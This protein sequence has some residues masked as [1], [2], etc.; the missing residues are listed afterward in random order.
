MADY[1]LTLPCATIDDTLIVSTYGMANKL[2]PE[3]E[4]TIDGTADD[5]QINAAI[6]SASAGQTVSLQGSSY[7]CTSTITINKSINF[8]LGMTTIIS[9]AD[10]VIA[11]TA[12]DVTVKGV[13]STLSKIINTTANETIIRS[14]GAARS[15]ITIANLYLEGSGPTYVAQDREDENLIWFGDSPD[16]GTHSNIRILNNYLTQSLTGI[17]FQSVDDSLI[18]GNT[19]LYSNA[20]GIQLNLWSCERVKIIGNSFYDSSAGAINAIEFLGSADDASSEIVVSNNT[21]WGSY[22]ETINIVGNKS[23]VTENT[24]YSN[25]G[26]NHQGIQLLQTTGHSACETYENIVSK[27]H[28]YIANALGNSAIGIKD[29]GDNYGVRRCIISE[30]VIYYNG[31]TASIATSGQNIDDNIIISNIINNQGNGLDG[32]YISGAT[33]EGN[34]IRTNWIDGVGR[35]GIYLNA[36]GQTIVDGNEVQNSTQS[37]IQITGGIEVSLINNRV[38]DN[39]TYGIRGEGAPT[40]K[41]LSGNV[42]YSNTTADIYITSGTVEQVSGNVPNVEVLTTGSPTLNSHINNYDIDSS[43]G[44]ITGTLG[45]GLFIGQIKTIS[46]SDATTSSTISVTNHVTSDPEVGTFDAVDE[47]WVLVWTGTEW[48]TLYASCTF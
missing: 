45:S 39:T 10:P 2:F 18:E 37:G 29:S 13:N 3:E 16:V 1:Q 47:T 22:L 38:R 17:L 6:V 4:G 24:I 23:I 14:V 5:V 42:A 25:G 21:F 43:G 36:P 30:N 8:E 34:I 20:G 9:T 28:I 40:I 12:D 32:V 46:M 44:A 19:F 15:N 7:T 41:L 33:C 48:A 11:I 31:V 35:H 27:N 26:T